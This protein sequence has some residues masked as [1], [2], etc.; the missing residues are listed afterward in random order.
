MLD[1]SQISMTPPSRLPPPRSFAE[2][3]AM[4]D[5][6]LGQLR[7]AEAALEKQLVTLSKYIDL[8]TPPMPVSPARPQ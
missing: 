4:V 5:A 1:L 2:A 7:N 6:A 8:N 3:T